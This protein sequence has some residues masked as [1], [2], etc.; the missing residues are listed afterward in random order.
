MYNEMCRINISAAAVLTKRSYADSRPNTLVFKLSMKDGLK[1]QQAILSRTLNLLNKI[2]TNEEER[3][4]LEEAK[5]H[6][7]TMPLKV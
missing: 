2:E 3:G 6:K 1:T 5:S 7:L 4:A